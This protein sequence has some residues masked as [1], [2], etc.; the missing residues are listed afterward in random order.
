MAGNMKGFLDR[1]SNPTSIIPEAQKRCMDPKMCASYTDGTKLCVEMALIA[2]GIGAI[3]PVPGMLGPRVPDIYQIF[4]HFDLDKL[5]DG[6]TPLVDFTLG[7]RPPGGVF[8]IGYTDHPH[9]VETL[10]W[11]PC[12]L[13]PGP[14]YVFH[15]PYH[16][17]HFEI[18]ACITEAFLDHQPLLQPRYGFSTNVYAYA[19]KDLRAGDVLDG[20]GGYTVYGLIENCADNRQHSGLPICLAE[21]T[22]LRRDIGKDEKIRLEDVEY[23]SSSPEFTLFRLAQESAP[24]ESPRK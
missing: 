7:T 2:N 24:Q 11:Y 14:F 23:D 9:Q 4:D 17:G 16:L 20:I 15:R 22:V 19:K 12:R 8:L 6:S 13:G 18:A 1:Y 3:T 10:S 5:W 21:N